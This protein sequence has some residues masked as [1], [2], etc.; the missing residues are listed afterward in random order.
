MPKDATTIIEWVS[1]HTRPV[2]VLED[3]GTFEAI[4]S[5]LVRKLDGKPIAESSCKRYRAIMN[6][7]HVVQTRAAA[8]GDARR[9]HTG[10]LRRR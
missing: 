9:F 4:F 2:A 7:F 8:L 6:K 10:R 3:A 1:E 5:K